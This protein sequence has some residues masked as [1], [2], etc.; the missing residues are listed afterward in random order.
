M[1]DPFTDNT[2]PFMSQASGPPVVK[3]A[4]LGD[5]VRGRVLSVVQQPDTKP[6]GSVAKWPSG[7]DMNVF[8]F[9]LMTAQGE[10]RLFVRGNMITAMR[11]ATR[12]AG[13]KTVIGLD[14]GVRHHALRKARPGFS[15]AKL[16]EVKV[17]G[18]APYGQ[19]TPP[20]PPQRQTAPV[21]TPAE[22]A[23]YIA[24]NNANDDIP[25]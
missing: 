16:Y 22:V 24:G 9:T 15:Q 7:E 8:V 10:M 6:D 20:P 2:D 4:A 14:I 11:E 3:F 25:F 21:L 18:P 1:Q 23:S 13:V 5:T 12:A 17:L 19:A